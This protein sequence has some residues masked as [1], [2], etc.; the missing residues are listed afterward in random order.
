MKG[1]ILWK[2]CSIQ[3]ILFLIP[4]L[5]M[6][7][8]VVTGKVTELNSGEPLPGVNIVVQGTNTGTISD[9]DGNY[10]I[11]VGDPNAVLEFSYVGYLSEEFEL[12]GATTAD[13]A[14]TEDILSL[15][16]LVVVG[17][18]TQ[19]KGDLTGSVAVVNTED[20]EKIESNNIAK[21]LQG[22]TPGVQVFGS[23][24]PGAIPKVQI[25]GVGS[26]NNT[27]PLYVIDGVPIAPATDI[28]A[29][30]GQ[31]IGF[32]DHAPGYGW[33][34]PA[35]GIADFNPSD[36]ESVQ[37]LKD[38]SA[39]A[40]YGSRG[41]NGVI[42]ITTKRGQTGKMKINYK[43]SYGWQNVVER[44][45]LTSRLAFQEINNIARLNDGS[46]M[47]R[48]NNPNRDEFI[49]SIDTDWQKEFFTTGHITD[50]S[51]SFNGGNENSSY[52][53]SI[54]YS[55][56]TSTVVGPGPRFTKYSAQ[57]NLDQKFGRFKFGQSFS[58]THTD[59][60]RMTSTRWNNLMTELVI[61]IPTVQLYDTAN[62][63]GYGGGSTNHNQIAG[64][65]VAFNNL[66]EVT[67]KRHRFLGTLYGEVEIFKGLS[68]RINLSYDRA[69]WF[70]KEFVP[71]YNVGD[72]HTSENPYLNEWRGE[73]PVMIVENLLRYQ[74]LFGRHD[75]N[76]LIGYTAQKD[77]IEDIYGHAEGFTE[78]YKKVLSGVPGGQTALNKRFEHTMISYLAR[79]NYAF[80]DRYLVTASIRR[81]Y[82]SNFGPNNKY[83][84][85]PSF[86][87][88]WKIS[89]ES[90]F[91]VPFISNL[92]L[93]GGWGK[94]GNEN[95]DPYL[96]E[97][98]VNNAVTYV[99]G[100]ELFPGTTQTR[101][102]D[103]SIKWE[104]RITS[105]GGFDL[106]ML[107]NKI[108]ISAEY[109][110][111]EANDILMQAPNGFPIPIS[112]GAV[113]WVIDAANGASMINKGFE[114]SA[115]YRKYEGDFH[116]RI[117]GS[118]TTLKNEVTKI[119]R[120]DIPI[121]T[122]T[123]K[124]EVGGE[125]G[126]L[127]AFATEGIFQSWDEIN[128]VG[129]DDAGFDP[130]RH[131]FQDANTQPGDVKFKDTNGRDENG[132]L[133]GLPDGRI[134]DDDK[135]YLGSAFPKFTYGLNLSFDY[136]NF[137]LSIFIQGVYGNKVYNEMYRVVNLLSEGNY[138]V[139]SYNNYWREETE[140][141][142]WDYDIGGVTTITLPERKGNTYPRP[143]VNDPNGNNRESDRWIQDGSYFR[144][145][146]V[147][148]G[149]NIP[150][151][152]VKGIQG[153]RVYVQAQNLFTFTKMTTY[154]PD[155]INDGLFNRGF[156]GGSY[157][158]P[159]TF[160]IGVNLSL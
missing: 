19:K 84:D 12:N 154:D 149:Y 61:A 137:D 157:P 131:A 100:T 127:Y 60:I 156:A 98:N 72:R 139:D 148:L 129:P 90:F 159:R 37:V 153:L 109:Y 35:G 87:L 75:I 13:M 93:R 102:V 32:E 44:F 14:M 53:A 51:L 125:M 31:S 140:L 103:P 144:V 29:V 71:L 50:H 88:G 134:D 113:G 41:A 85:F 47:A 76:A 36:I 16:E 97:T 116:F 118:I 70:N 65:P 26:F 107:Q 39:A 108:E 120:T 83:G 119:G 17:Y 10:S 18:G 1:K 123:S 8:H 66:R 23:G 138:S 126:Q 22:Q 42:I 111:N 52:Y 78:P 122:G 21:I 63:G 147:M 136:K 9:I 114:I 11:D 105:Y 56:Q 6:A 128:T 142:V 79:I 82:S 155:F 43:G 151:D 106:A 30:S 77:H 49:D 59:Q 69:D 96:Y 130:N 38:A 57:L 89:N 48:T 101:A 15:E 58:Y 117:N 5:A 27:D 80:D 81:D 2:L 4:G 91:N 150:M 67:F 152:R 99:F 158:A 64:N 104:E 28:N 46:F 62:V 33:G 133:T 110:Y 141:D 20:L 146:N 92:K 54:N 143:T 68:Y 95:I 40:I 132:E 121:T 160:L 112:S 7:Q 45:D 86:A 34:A 73:Y 74:R 24:E 115:G 124:T 135:V 94:I 25:R 3:L 55:D 145:Q